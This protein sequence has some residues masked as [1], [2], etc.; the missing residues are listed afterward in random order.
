MDTAC[1]L[2]PSFHIFCLYDIEINFEDLLKRC[3]INKR[4]EDGWT[5]LMIAYLNSLENQ[6]EILMKHNAEFTSAD[7]RTVDE[8]HRDRPL[9][10]HD[11]MVEYI[12]KRF[13][14]TKACRKK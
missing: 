13:R 4:K 2:W 7:L 9:H 1:S 10:Y 11:T 6:M 12:E 8:Y 3:D 5:A 14:R